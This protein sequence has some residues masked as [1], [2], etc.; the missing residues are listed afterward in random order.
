MLH[1]VLSVSAT[2]VHQADKVIA[3]IGLLQTVPPTHALL[4][5]GLKPSTSS[6]FDPTLCGSKASKTGVK[7]HPRGAVC[8]V[9]APCRSVALSRQTLWSS[10]HCRTLLRHSG[11]WGAHQQP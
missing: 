3:C 5:L 1:W 8:A 9:Q 4:C 11:V 7:A 10:L 2:Y 6:S